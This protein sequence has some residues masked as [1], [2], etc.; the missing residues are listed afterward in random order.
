MSGTAPETAHAAPRRRLKFAAAIGVLLLIAA[1]GLDYALQP[2]RATALLLREAGERL[3]L[4]IRAARADY[5]LRGAPQLVLHDM[6]A[7]RP[8]DGV[9]LLRAERVLVAL[10]WRTLRSRGAEL[11]VQ[12]IE[13]DAPVLDIPALQRWLATRPPSGER[14]IPTLTRGLRIVRGRIHHQGWRIEDIAL[15]LPALAPGS[16]LQARVRGRYLDPPVRLPFDLDLAMTAPANGAGMAALGQVAV[17]ADA[18]RMPG[19]LHLSG[20]LRFGDDGLRMTPARVGLA[21]RYRSSTSDLP[22]VLGAYGPMQFDAGVWALQ[23]AQLQLR[24]AGPIPRADA[25][26]A[27][28]LGRRLVLRLHGRIAAWP[29]AWPALPAPLAHSS[30]PLA[31][32]LDY[33]GR[34]NLA[35]TSDLRL[36]RDAT[37]FEA[38]FRLPRV[39]DWL[40]A[41]GAGTPLPPLDG[42]LRTPRLDIAGA[43]LHGVEMDFADE[44]A[45]PPPALR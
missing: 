9:A 34:A 26:G 18:W 41:D 38:R 3:G 11:S 5:R 16:P 32:A 45:P 23:P 6:V 37:R 12:R 1:F 17:E 14:R 21:A 29:A 40:E 42:H 30:S 10:P 13:L 31:F 7:Q 25:R 8:G 39:Q 27:I 20:P 2:Q 4:D 36:R 15:D 28:A 33:A 43:Q 24:G 22:F 44:A 35:D 19:R